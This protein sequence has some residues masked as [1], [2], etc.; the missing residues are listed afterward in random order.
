MITAYNDGG[1]RRRLHYKQVHCIVWGTF[2]CT[3]QPWLSDVCVCELTLRQCCCSPKKVGG[4][5]EIQCTEGGKAK[6]SEK[7]NAIA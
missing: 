4:I 7:M 6:T 5:F 2:L 1:W 3:C